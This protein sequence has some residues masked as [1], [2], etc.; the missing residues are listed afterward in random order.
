[1]SAGPEK[2]APAPELLFVPLGGAGEIGMNLNL[3]AYGDEW[4]MV[5]LGVTF[6]DQP[7]LDVIMPDPAFIVERRDKLLGIVLTHAHED[8]IGAVQYL[9]SQL[10]CPIYATPFTASILK[11]KLAETGLE[12]LAEI[13]VVPLGARFRLGPFEF[14][15]ITLTHSIPE[16][17]A[18]AIRTPLGTI[19]HTGDWKIDPDPL[20]GEATDDAAL[21]RVGEEGVLAMVCDS[22]NVLREGTSGSEADLRKSLVEIVGRCAQRV[23]IACFASNVAR[24]E[25]VAKVAE[26]HGR[27]AALVG[28][29]LWR[30]YEAAVENGYLKDIPRFLD[31]AEA[32]YL[33]RDRVVLAM[34]GSQG[35]PRS[36]LARVVAG[37]HPHISLERGDTAIFSSRIIPGNER[38]IFRLQSGL[39]R[40]GVEIVTEH[41]EFVHV[42]GHPAR[43]ELA[44]MY[45]WVKPRIAVPVHGEMRHLIEHARFARACQIREAAVVTNG[46]ILRLAPGAVEIVGQAQAGRL[47]LDGT[48]LVPA[49]GQT[50]KS[51]TRMLWHGAAVATVVVARDGHLAS[52]PQLA[53]PGLADGDGAAG[54]VA[55]TADAIEDAVEELP[56][57]ARGDD[58]AL[59]EAVRLAIRRHVRLARGKKPAIEVHLVRL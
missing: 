21:R 5:D 57:A 7:G 29:S 48:E 6:A 46:D 25:T 30:F 11:R 18:L 52:A 41:D 20:V 4:V 36:A 34:T 27:Q 40:L 59:K 39:A 31:D 23:A 51:R 43:D 58:A 42:S 56:P 49:E 32:A 26:A 38:A 3:Y 24:L 44:E 33:P 19:L 16:P 53:L 22:T 55:E 2:A 9:W 50:V 15:L 13:T 28:R 47:A 14:E 17:N 37:E 8:H 1:M 35:E 12:R 45:A 10:R 54:L